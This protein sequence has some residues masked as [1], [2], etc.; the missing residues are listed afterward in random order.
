MHDAPHGSGRAGWLVRELDHHDL[1]VFR[2]TELHAGHQHPV[3]DA[4]IVRREVGHARFEAQPPHHFFRT[5]L[6]HFDDRALGAA[7]EA[8]GF[9][10]H[11][12]P[13]AVDD[14]AHLRSRQVNGTRAVVGQQRAVAVA[15][16]LHR[17]DDEARDLLAQA[18]L[19][20]AVE[21]HFAAFQQL[22]EFLLRLRG[23]GGPEGLGHLVKSQWP[24]R[25]PQHVQHGGF[26]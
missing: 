20:A 8:R 15:R 6:E 9:D 5:A 25:L 21:H 24:A 2:T 19:A 23:T 26:G 4:G 14:F 7:A 1:P 11:R 12:K 17:A 10:A 13:V 16:A 18:I 3:W 22:L